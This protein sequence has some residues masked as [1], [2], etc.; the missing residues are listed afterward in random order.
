MIPY[1]IGFGQYHISPVLKAGAAGLPIPLNI[2]P[3][4]YPWYNNSFL[5]P[6]DSIQ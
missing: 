5:P 2:F 3:Q 6:Y 4:T 1:M